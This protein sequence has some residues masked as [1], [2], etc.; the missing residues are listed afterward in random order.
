MPDL[1]EA[2]ERLTRIAEFRPIGMHWTMEDAGACTTVLARLAALERECK[3]WRAFDWENWPQ[4][5]PK[6]T[7]DWNA[8]D[9]ELREA[10][11]ATDATNP[12]KEVTP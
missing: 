9:K 5:H 7:P 2:V 6:G 11:A 8:A 1:R 12:P 10:R 3:A 4:E